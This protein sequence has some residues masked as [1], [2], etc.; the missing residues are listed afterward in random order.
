MKA[1]LVTLA[2]ISIFTIARG[3][4]G[5][6]TYYSKLFTPV[7]Q[8]AVFPGGESAFHKF[9][10]KNFKYPK[11]SENSFG[12]IIVAFTIK[13]DGS[14]SDIHVIKSISP[15]VDQ[16]VIRVFKMSK[17]YPCIKDGRP[18]RVKRKLAIY[19]EPSLSD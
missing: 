8:N 11:T 4:Q 15:E 6:S 3:Q 17:W 5:D 2:F 18:V 13:K 12:K 1:I 9:F 14:L 7:N 19:I 10:F 16:Q